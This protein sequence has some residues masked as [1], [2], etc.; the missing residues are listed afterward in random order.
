MTTYCMRAEAPGRS[1]WPSAIFLVSSSHSWLS[2]FDM[3]SSLDRR[4]R[5]AAARPEDRARRIVGACYRAA[6][7]RTPAKRS[8]SIT[9]SPVGPTRLRARMYSSTGWMV[10][11]TS[12]GS[13]NQNGDV[14]STWVAWASRAWRRTSA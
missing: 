8:S 5:T 10:R 3:S 11:A 4:R 1:G 2:H 13:P 14:G 7:S 9:P 6:R 12:G